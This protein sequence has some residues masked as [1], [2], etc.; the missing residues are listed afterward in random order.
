M[1]ASTSLSGAESELKGSNYVVLADTD[2]FIVPHFLQSVS[3]WNCIQC[4]KQ[5]RPRRA[6]LLL[7]SRV[8][9]GFQSV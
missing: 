6:L 1:P 8:A 3:I 4:N 9:D 5:K 7:T 2:K